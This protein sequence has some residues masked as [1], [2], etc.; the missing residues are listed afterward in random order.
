V[1][2]KM[3]LVMDGRMTPTRLRRE[4]EQ[5]AEV[6]IAAYQEMANT[7]DQGDYLATLSLFTQIRAA[8]EQLMSAL[9]QAAREHQNASWRDIGEAL[10]LHRS[11]AQ[12]RFGRPH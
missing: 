12:Q 4:L 11:S 1:D 9:V 10:G 7:F 8:R 6:V 5:T 3:T 2:G